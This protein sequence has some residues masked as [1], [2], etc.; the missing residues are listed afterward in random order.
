MHGRAWDGLPGQ[1][2]VLPLEHPP[3]AASSQRGTLGL[4][5]ARC[6]VGTGGE[7]TT[8]VKERWHW[9]GSRAHLVG[10]V[11]PQGENN[12]IPEGTVVLVLLRRSLGGGCSILGSAQMGGGDGGHRACIQVCPHQL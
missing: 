4:I 8:A 6:S 5:A 2:L 1:W 9:A 11:E 10:Y 3:G 7:S 12:P